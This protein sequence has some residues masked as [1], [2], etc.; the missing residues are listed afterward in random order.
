MNYAKQ[1]W[2]AEYSR[3]VNLRHLDDGGFRFAIPAAPGHVNYVLTREFFP[4]SGIRT[5]TLRFRIAGR[6]GMEFSEDVGEN[7]PGTMPP[8]VGVVLS[9]ATQDGRWFSRHRIA[10]AKGLHGQR[11]TL[12]EPDEW[13]GVWGENGSQGNRFNRFRL[14]HAQIGLCFGG[15]NDYGH[16]VRMKKGRATFVLETFFGK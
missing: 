3:G 4:L 10:L 9:K 7:D 14:T 13:G 8:S 11:L 2:Q 16:G 6:D 15:G 12:D 5:L 1:G